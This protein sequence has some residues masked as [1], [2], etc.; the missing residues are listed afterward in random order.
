MNPVKWLIWGISISSMGG[1]HYHADTP[2]YP[3]LR[4]HQ[5]APPGQAEAVSKTLTVPLFISGAAT[6]LPV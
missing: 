3:I 1:L 6:L 4:P 5:T 2:V